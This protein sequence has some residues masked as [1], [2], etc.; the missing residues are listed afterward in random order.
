M[1]LDRWET[2]SSRPALRTNPSRQ[3]FQLRVDGSTA[4][5]AVRE[6]LRR[7]LVVCDEWLGSNAYAGMK[8]LRRCGWSVTTV[9]EREFVP[10]RWRSPAYKIVGRAVRSAGAREFHREICLL[11]ERL[12]PELLLVFKGMFVAAETLRHLRERGVR[13]YCFFPDVS[14]R[15]HGPYIPDAL[16]QYDWVFSTKTYGLRDMREQLGVTRASLLRHAFDADLHRP[17]AAEAVDRARYACDVSYIGTWSPKK[18]RLLGAVAAQRPDLRLRI[19]GEQWDRATSP[20]V[21]RGIGGHEVAGEEYVHAISASKINLGILSEQRTGAS[22]GDQITSRTFHIPACAGFMLHER[23]EELLSIFREGHD[24]A[25]FGDETELLASIGRYVDDEP[26]RLRI[27]L[28]GRRIVEHA[29]SW[30]HRIRE[31]L[32]HH[33]TQGRSELRPP[34]GAPTSQHQSDT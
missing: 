12:R 13:S 19:W 10:L 9:P 31:I 5:P 21:R 16:P 22:A 18:E 3:P 23:T 17:I 34:R 7:A 33:D 26:A 24:V 6:P 25:C 29:H 30:D 8:A 1:G 11:A 4:D 28:A 14:F 2:G 15:V 32:A 20:D 27:A